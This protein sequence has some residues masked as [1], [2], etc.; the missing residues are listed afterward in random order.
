MSSYSNAYAAGLRRAAYGTKVTDSSG[1]VHMYVKASTTAVVGSL[2]FLAPGADPWQATLHSSGGLG[3]STVQGGM[4]GIQDSTAGTTTQDCWLSVAGPMNALVD[5]TN[6]AAGVS[7]FMSTTIAGAMSV[8][9]TGARLYGV[10]IQS[11]AGAGLSAPVLTPVMA[12][13]GLIIN[14][15]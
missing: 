12:P 15:A 1:G 14:I 8:T 2:V 13:F 3:I 9:T 10:Y 11:S 4:L 5:S 6:A 7:L